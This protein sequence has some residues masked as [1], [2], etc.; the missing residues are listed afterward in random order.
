MVL[1]LTEENFNEEVL[2]ADEPVL[3]DFWAAWC[4]PCRTIAPVI[5]ALEERYG[6]ALK[7]AKVNVDEHSEIAEHYRVS[8]IPTVFIFKDGKIVERLI[9]A[10]TIQAY[11]EAIKK[12][13]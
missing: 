11:E 8:S 10:H 9:G 2:Q 13:I 7:F 4:G 1:L 6:E 12:Y 3:V 5:D